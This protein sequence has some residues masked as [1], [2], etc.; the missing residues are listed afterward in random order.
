MRVLIVQVFQAV[1][2]YPFVLDAMMARASFEARPL[3]PRGVSA[4]VRSTVRALAAVR[5][6]AQQTHVG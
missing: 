2:G 5:P 4:C 1:G 3:R 6:V